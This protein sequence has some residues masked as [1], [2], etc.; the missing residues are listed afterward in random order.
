LHLPTNTIRNLRIIYKNQIDAGELERVI[1]EV[2]L[3][4]DLNHP[5]VIKIYEAFSDA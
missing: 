1:N 2:K 5:N 4:R 3:A